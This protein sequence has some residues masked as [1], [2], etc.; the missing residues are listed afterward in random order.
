MFPVVLCFFFVSRLN[1][2]VL[3]FF[4]VVPPRSQFLCFFLPRPPRALEKE[5]HGNNTHLILFAFRG[6]LRKRPLRKII[7]FFLWWISFVHNM[8]LLDILGICFE[9]TKDSLLLFICCDIVLLVFGEELFSVQLVSCASIFWIRSV[10]CLC[11]F[12]FG[13][14]CFFRFLLGSVFCFAHL[15]HLGLFFLRCC[16][17]VL[18]F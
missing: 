5:N 18:V 8:F 15:P 10:L 14:F 12:S 6:S 4:L 7:V 13:C 2:F 1:V 11:F 9:G 17:V 3:C 16:V